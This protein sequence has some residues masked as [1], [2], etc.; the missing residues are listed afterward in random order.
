MERVSIVIPTLNRADYLDGCL[1]ALADLDYPRDRYEVVVVDGGS[2]DETPAVVK[3]HAANFASLR[4]LVETKKGSS[5]AR[6][7]GFQHVEHDYVAL[8]DD[9]AVVHQDWLKNFMARADKDKLLVGKVV[10]YENGNVQYGCRRS[11]FIGG[12]I[13]LPDFLKRFANHGCTC[14]MFVP[15]QVWNTIGGFDEE[16]ITAFD[17]SSFCL[18]ALLHGYNV[19]YVDDA[20]VFH[21]RELKRPERFAQ[22]IMYRTYGMLKIYTDSRLQRILFSFLNAVYVYLQFCVFLYKYGWQFATNAVK[23]MFQGHRLYKQKMALV[24]SEDVPSA[25]RT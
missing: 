21:K 12:S 5:A 8:T 1:Q 3:K 4:L 18:H 14:N 2:T 15:K 13:P 22:H 25:Q 11:T 24:I 10:S 7:F 23:A 20:A 19:Q 16:L 17:D 9:D 6:N